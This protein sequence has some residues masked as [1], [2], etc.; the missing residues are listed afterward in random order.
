MRLY[1]KQLDKRRNN[2]FTKTFPELAYMMEED[3]YG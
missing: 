1:I 3:Y 2:D